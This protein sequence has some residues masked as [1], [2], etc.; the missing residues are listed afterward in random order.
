M[1]YS[2]LLF[3]ICSVYAEIRSLVLIYRVCSLC[4]FALDLPD[5]HMNCCITLE[6][7]Y[8]T[9]MCA[10]LNYLISELLMY[11]VCGME[12]YI[13][14]SVFEEILIFRIS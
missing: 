10:G 5:L 9:G 2:Y 1:P 4:L 8:P 13:Q 3:S 12:G 11:S 14:I 7:M 6:F